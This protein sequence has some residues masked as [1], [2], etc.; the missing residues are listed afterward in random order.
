MLRRV[1]SAA[2]VLALF[3]FAPLVALSTQSWVTI[4]CARVPAFVCD[5]AEQTVFA[6]DT[7]S[8]EVRGARVATVVNRSRSGT[9][10]ENY[11]IVFD[12]PLGAVDALEHETDERDEAIAIAANLDAAIASGTPAFEATLAPGIGLWVSSALVAVFAALGLWLGIRSIRGQSARR[13]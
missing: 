8:F 3:T 9:V 6:S 2:V 12:T 10:V 4:R 5:V 11:Q 1:V 7:R 13:S